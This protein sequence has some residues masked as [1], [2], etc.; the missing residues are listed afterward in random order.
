VNAVQDDDP[1]KL[2]GPGGLTLRQVHEQVQKSVA[3]DREAR[4]NQPPVQ[5]QNLWQRLLGY[6]RR[7]A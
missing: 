2:K 3:R 5:K 6:L 7:R 1:D 4:S